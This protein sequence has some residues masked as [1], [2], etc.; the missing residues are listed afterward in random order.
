MIFF[1]NNFKKLVF[2]VGKKINNVFSI[3]IIAII[4]G[5][6]DLIGFSIILPFI[7]IIMGPGGSENLKNNYLLDYLNISAETDNFFFILAILLILDLLFMKVCMIK[8]L[9]LK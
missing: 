3:V 1:L 7:T 4:S 2:I 9:N 5:L 6:I 8:F